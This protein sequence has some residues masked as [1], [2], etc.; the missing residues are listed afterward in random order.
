MLA[1]RQKEER[2][3]LAVTVGTGAACQKLLP[4]HC[5]APTS[6]REAK[7]FQG[8]HDLGK[9]EKIKNLSETIGCLKKTE[10]CQIERL[11]ILLPVGKKYL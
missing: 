10:F 7:A 5:I 11:Q 3:R 1:V 6:S 2:A 4:M 8:T 9:T